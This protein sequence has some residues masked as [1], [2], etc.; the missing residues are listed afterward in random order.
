MENDGDSMP[1]R[2]KLPCRHPGCPNL[3]E[4]GS[5]YCEQHRTAHPNSMVS[6]VR[7]SAA[8]R[9]YGHRWQKAREIYLH[10]HPLCERCKEEGR[11]VMATVVDHIYPHQGN[12]KLFWDENNWQALCKRCHDRKTRTEDMSIQ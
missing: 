9:G 4:A 11:Y 8:K 6:G 2:A 12:Q 5:P 10:K 7:P 1:R 3:T